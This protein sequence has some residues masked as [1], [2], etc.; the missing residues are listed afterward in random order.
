MHVRELVSEQQYR[1]WFRAVRQQDAGDG[2]IRLLVPN[3][4]VMDWISNYFPDI[5][6]QAVR[7]CY[8]DD[9]KISLALDPDTP[10]APKIERE[11]PPMP[12]AAPPAAPGDSSL[13]RSSDTS[14][15][16][17]YT[18]EN[19]VVGTSNRFAHAAATAVAEAPGKS[20]NP[21]F[22]HGSVGLG[23]THLLQA[24]C[25]QIL[26]KDRRANILYLSCESFTNHFIASLENN[27]LPAFRQKYR[28]VDVLLVDDIHLLANKERTQEEF[29]HTFNTIY[30]LGRQIAISSDAPPKDIPTLQE[31]LV[32]R[33][34]MG[35]VVEIAPPDFETRV[36][37]LKR[38]ARLRGHTLPDDVSHYL[39][40]HI[41]TNI[42][43]LEGSV[44]RLIG[45]AALENQPI[46]L[47]LA[48][49]ALS[50]AT[51]AR[52]TAVTIHDIVSA[53]TRYFN[54]KLSDLQS[55]RRTQS[56]AF[57][58]QVCMYVARQNTNLS[59]EEIGGYFGGRDHTTV[60]YATEKIKRMIDEDP[61]QAEIIRR[62]EKTVRG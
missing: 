28:K 27:D 8:G 33:F 46:S 18:F 59:L 42:R 53:V 11:R 32:S 14:L 57:P 17:E 61:H 60:I 55:K 37:I 22:L 39:A 41:S 23:K 5:L 52:A 51:A 29:F 47:D 31:R 21:F 38:K 35:L 45:Y 2:S 10:P 30:N 40:E 13:A 20:Y 26:A 49:V 7:R 3:D 34:K 50:D 9:R 44:V 36:N 4:F 48:R 56:I 25:H 16:E 6:A 43:E 24:I 58:R 62:L 54:V 19:F 12:P 1:T 15:H